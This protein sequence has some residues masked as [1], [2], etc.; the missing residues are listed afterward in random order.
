MYLGEA[1]WRRDARIERT[2]GE[3]Y[4]GV[5]VFA[6]ESAGGHVGGA[7]A[8]MRVSDAALAIVDGTSD[9]VARNLALGLHCY[10]RSRQQQN[11][12][13]ES[14][15]RLLHASIKHDQYTP[16]IVRNFMGL[17]TGG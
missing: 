10:G 13:Q 17:K 2:G 5:V 11:H 7:G 14:L 12:G 15:R 9:G 16:R 3:F 6:K 4:G 8:P 1:A